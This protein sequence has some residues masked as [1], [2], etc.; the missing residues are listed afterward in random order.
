MIPAILCLVQFLYPTIFL[1]GIFFI[2]F[3][4][5]SAVYSFLLITDIYKIIVGIRPSTLLDIDDSV[6]FILLL[7]IL[8][9]ITY[10]LF[11]SRPQLTPIKE[12]AER[13]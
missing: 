12:T 8:I 10:I 6:V 3:L 4:S 2:I 13:G 1:W 11:I 9:G 5:G 7:A